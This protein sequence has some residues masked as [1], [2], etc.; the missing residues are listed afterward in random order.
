M[1]VWI[2]TSN[3]WEPLHRL[4]NL[5]STASALAAADEILTPMATASAT[6]TAAEVFPSTATASATA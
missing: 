4:S 3:T 2:S 1:K 6:A 5:R